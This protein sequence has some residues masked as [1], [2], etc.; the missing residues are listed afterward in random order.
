M[1]FALQMPDLQIDITLEKIDSTIEALIFAAEKPITLEEIKSC[2]EEVMDSML[3][4]AAIE[5]SINRVRLKYDSE[6]CGFGIYSVAGGIQFM[7]KPAF[8]HAVGILIKQSS[9]KRL[10]RS[11]LETLSIIAYRQPI[12]K[13]E[14]E[15][16]RG[17]NCDYALQKLLD[18]ELVQI[19]GRSQSLGRP[20][21]YGT[22][23]KFMEYFGLSDLNEL[24]A[25][26]DFRTT[27]NQI[28]EE[29]DPIIS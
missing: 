28:G 13:G 26:K 17:V 7:T 23:Q 11:A 29:E 20:L 18:K 5:E 21:L 19:I 27:D 8:H 6:Q 15:K 4:V 25:L 16:I 24:P 3:E 14:V 2:L 10:S 1:N 9:K 22:S 12:S